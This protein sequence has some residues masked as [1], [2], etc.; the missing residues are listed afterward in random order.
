MAGGG[1]ERLGGIDRA[2]YIAVLTHDPKIDDQVLQLA[3]ASDPAYI[4]AM[5]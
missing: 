3:L 2:T 4:G 5:G 1:G